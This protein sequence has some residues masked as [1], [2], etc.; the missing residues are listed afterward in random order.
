MNWTGAFSTVRH[1]HKTWIKIPGWSIIYLLVAVMLVATSTLLV[2]Q[3]FTKDSGVGFVGGV[4]NGL[5]IL[6]ICPSFCC[7]VCFSLCTVTSMHSLLLVTHC[8]PLSLC[9]VCLSFSTYVSALP[10]VGFTLLCSFEQIL[11]Y[12]YDKLAIMLNDVENHRTHEEYDNALIYKKFCFQW[13]CTIHNAQSQQN[14]VCRFINNYG[15]LLYVA[16]IKPLGENYKITLWPTSATD[17]CIADF[18][19]D[20]G[21]EPSRNCYDELQY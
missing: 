15:T 9:T 6:V 19:H 11:N 21:D 2:F 8:S 14:V 17:Y 7:L 13:V 3:I 12:F 4:A 1:V 20:Y 5:S 18:D 10:S 16:F